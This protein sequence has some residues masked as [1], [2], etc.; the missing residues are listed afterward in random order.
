MR[1]RI[2]PD[3]VQPLAV[4]LPQ[5]LQEGNRGPGVAVALQFHPFHLA[6]LRA[7]RLA[8]AGLRP[9]ARAGSSPPTLVLP[10]APTCPATR[11][12]HGSAPR[13]QRKPWL[14]SAGPP[15]SGPRTPQRR[16][17]SW[18]HQL[19]GPLEGESQAVQIVEATAPAQADAE[20]FRDKLPD[21][22]PIPVG[23]FHSRRWRR[24]LHCRFQL[25][26]PRL[27]QGEG[28][29]RSARTSGPQALPRRRPT[30]A[31]RWYVGPAPAP[32]PWPLPSILGPS[33]R[34]CTTVPSP[35]VSRA[36]AKHTTVA[37]RKC[38]TGVMPEGADLGVGVATGTVVGGPWEDY[39]PACSGAEDSVAFCRLPLRR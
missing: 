24:L 1:R 16:P 28:E 27:V 31:V 18:R 17:P 32:P 20:P 22:F 23:Q 38:T 19:L 3:H 30:P 34:R 26:L 21:G 13:R 37:E 35:G 39:G 29:P 10:S 8:I 14:R 2:V 15:P 25:L 11:P 7:H 33:A 36:A 5:L 6:P 4:L 12:R 9:V